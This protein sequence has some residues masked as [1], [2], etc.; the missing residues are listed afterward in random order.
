METH[1]T[2]APANTLV[3]FQGPDAISLSISTFDQTGNPADE[4][5]TT[6]TMR[7]AS[8]DATWSFGAPADTVIGGEPAQSVSYTVTRKDPVTGQPINGQTLTGTL[9]V[10]N[11]GGK[12]YNFEAVNIGNQA[13]DV[14]MILA[15]VIFG[16]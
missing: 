8:T 5:Q 7:E 3:I 12:R 9:W 10:V 2:S 15:T 16:S 13:A 6:K 1:P 4:L 14:N 11:Y